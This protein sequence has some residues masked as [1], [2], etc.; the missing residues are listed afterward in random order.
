M[1]KALVGFAVL[2]LIIAFVSR[3][4][5]WVGTATFLAG[6]PSGLLA[7]ITA[8]D[9]VAG[10]FGAL[11]HLGSWSTFLF[12]GVALTASCMYWWLCF[13]GLNAAKTLG[14]F[15]RPK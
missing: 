12:A 11:E 2:A 3:W 7:L 1:A 14:E 13:V 6:V 10:F 8:L 9:V 4:G 5:I 15:A